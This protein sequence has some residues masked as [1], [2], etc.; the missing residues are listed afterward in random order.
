M[1]VTRRQRQQQQPLSL[2]FTLA[3]AIP[4]RSMRHSTDI[5]APFRPFNG[6]GPFIPP[7]ATHPALHCRAGLPDG[8]FSNQNPIF[9]KFWMVLE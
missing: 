4:Q 9:G 5:R 3:L 2:L 8:L 7:V 6:K 1:K